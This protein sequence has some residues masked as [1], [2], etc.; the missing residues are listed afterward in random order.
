[1]TSG[2][3][4]SLPGLKKWNLLV[5][6]SVFYRWT[7]LF[8]L[9]PDWNIAQGTLPPRSV[10]GGARPDSNPRQLSQGW[11]SLTNWP[12]HRRNSYT[13]S[14]FTVHTV[15]TAN[16]FFLFLSPLPPVCVCVCADLL[17]YSWWPDVSPVTL[18]LTASNLYIWTDTGPPPSVNRQQ[19]VIEYFDMTYEYKLTH[20][21]T[22][23]LE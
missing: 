10:H 19:I 20:L 2:L 14:L 7:S 22:C 21:Q 3:S 4:V 13:T 6:L 11:W 17:G 9:S 15:H 8:P 16:R 1:M 5:K 12:L 18:T 23:Y